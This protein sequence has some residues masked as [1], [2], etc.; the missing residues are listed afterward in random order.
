[1]HSTKIYNKKNHAF[2]PHTK[3][4][5]YIIN[6]DQISVPNNSQ[7]PVSW[8]HVLVHTTQ[9]MQIQYSVDSGAGQSKCT[10]RG[11]QKDYCLRDFVLLF[12]IKFLSW[13]EIVINRRLCNT[14]FFCQYVI[15]GWTSGQK[16]FKGCQHEQRLYFFFQCV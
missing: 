12:W 1:L 16:F 5:L 10:F 9:Q 8:L 6:F 14:V 15:Q 7:L 13:N 2:F 11:V 3:D 4:T